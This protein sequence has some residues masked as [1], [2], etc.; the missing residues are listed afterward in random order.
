MNQNMNDRAVRMKTGDLAI[1]TDLQRFTVHDGPGIRTMVF[2]KGCPL[3]CKWCH[4]PET[5]EV[6]PEIMHSKSVCIKCGYCLKACDKQAI[7]IK[8]GEIK[9]NRSLCNGCGKCTKTCYA[10]ALR[11]AGKYVTI[12]E[13]FDAVME[14]LPFYKNKGGV[15]LSGGECTMQPVFVRKLLKKF[16]ENGVH[17]AIETCGMCSTAVFKSILEY[18]D[19]VLFDIKVP[20]DE[21]S[22]YYVG[23]D[24]KLILHNLEATSQ[25]GKDIV[26]RFP[27]IPGVNDDEVSIRK[28]AGIAVQNKIHR[29]NVLPFHQIAEGKWNE[30]GREYMMAGK[31]LPSDESIERA[32]KIFSEYGLDASEG[33]SK[34]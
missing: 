11:L 21:Q 22:K 2:F 26:V 30:L 12:D 27:L 10:K 31:E 19:L 32:L 14:D 20:N 17:T 7:F 4:N 1:I 23:C 15:T 34:A 29:L 28:V 5:W 25:M 18:V 24:T 6:Y 3:R 8:D 13:V 9:I 33:G 16:K